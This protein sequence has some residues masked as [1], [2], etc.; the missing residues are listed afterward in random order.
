MTWRGFKV[1][2]GPSVELAAWLL[3]AALALL[4]LWLALRLVLQFVP[5][6]NLV[7]L[8]ELSVAAPVAAPARSLA[9]WH[10]FGETPSAGGGSA[11]QAGAPVSLILRGTLADADPRA[12]VAIVAQAGADERALRVGEEAEPGLRLLRVYVDRAVF[13]RSGVEH[14]L[15]LPRELPRTAPM[16]REP[17]AGSPAATDPRLLRALPLPATAANVAAR[18]TSATP[19]A[20]RE[21]AAAARRDPS[22][23]LQRLKVEPVFADGRFGGLRVDA[24]SS[25]D[26]ELL[27]AAGLQPGDVITQ[28]DGS[29]IDSISSGQQVLARLGSANSVRVTVERNGRPLELSLGIP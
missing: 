2:R 27:R 10:L 28:V 25:A 9:S 5:D 17:A 8:R 29:A 13:A 22:S 6:G 23:I 4:A 26:G 16:P 12:G 3:C 21:A 11:A 18:P 20:L 1:E 19:A 14:V 7:K 15:Q 24:R